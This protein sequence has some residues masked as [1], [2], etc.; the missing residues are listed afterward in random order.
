MLFCDGGLVGV[1]PKNNMYIL[2][3]YIHVYIASG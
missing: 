2:Y 1:N 3:T